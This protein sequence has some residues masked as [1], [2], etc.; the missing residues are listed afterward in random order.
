M[1]GHTDAVDMAKLLCRRFEGFSARPYICPAGVWT[2]G[3][4]ATRGLSGR[5]VTGRHRAISKEE[6]EALLERDLLKILPG[7]LVACPVVSETS[8]RLAA[9]LDFTFNLGLGRLRSSTL[10][11]RVNESDW[12]GAE[13]EIRRWVFA[14]GRKLRGL[15]I[16]REAEARLLGVDG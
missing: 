12:A 1:A 4:G 11:R 15:I 2:I 8:F 14:G 9:L 16:R 7:V 13:A 6:G 10:R 5:A 3:Y